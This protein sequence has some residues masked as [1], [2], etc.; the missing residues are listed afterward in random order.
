MTGR[1][2][3]L[4]LALFCAAAPVLAQAPAAA[5]PADA[6]ARRLG[7]DYS[8]LQ[9][10]RLGSREDRDSQVAA[11]LIGLPNLA[12]GAPAPGHD[13]LLRQLLDAH[14]DDVL[15]LYAL[16]LACQEL[17]APCAGAG[18]YDKLVQLA[19]GNAVHWLL[20]PRGAAVDRQRL[21]SAAQAGAA[22]S[23]HGA[24]L[25]IVR[26]A[27]ADQPAPAAPDAGVSP[28]ALALALRREELAAIPWPAY[29]PAMALCSA[30]AAKAS[31][32]P[33]AVEGETLRSDCAN[34]GRALFADQGLQVVTRMYGSTLLRRFAPRSQLA[35][36][37]KEFRRQWLWLDQLRA[38]SNP[39]AR[40]TLD[41]ETAALGEWEALQRQ[42]ERSGSTRG[43]PPDWLPGD[44]ALLQLPEERRPGL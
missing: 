26:A 29:G 10:Q 25:A 37:A 3:P 20:R 33:R 1:R 12:G 24:L 7:N 14:G 21:H 43:P 8:A 27:L 18:A 19:P 6:Q 32:D 5:T 41:Q 34:L 9:L 42:A 40:E 4:L 35:T 39:D 17:P 15:A 31:A 30:Q 22:D 36:E 28:Q 2:L 44:H 16:A 23:H 38:G 13:L 11:V